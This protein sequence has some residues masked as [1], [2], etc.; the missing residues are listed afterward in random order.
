[1]YVPGSLLSQDVAEL[2]RIVR[3]GCSMPGVRTAYADVRLL[4]ADAAAGPAL[5]ATATLAPATLTCAGA[6]T[7]VSL[8]GAATTLRIELAHAGAGYL[9][10]AQQVVR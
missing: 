5:L 3:P 2:D 9:I 4:P 7:A 10:R 1:V 8:G 6:A